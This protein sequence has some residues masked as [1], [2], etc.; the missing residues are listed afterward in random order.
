MRFYHLLPV[1]MNIII[2]IIKAGERVEKR[3]P[4]YTVGG[5]VN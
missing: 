3:K 1:K 2:Q 4:C 5:N